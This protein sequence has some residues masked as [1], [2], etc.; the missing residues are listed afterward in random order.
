MACDWN[1][2]NFFLKEM[3]M[4]PAATRADNIYYANHTKKITAKNLDIVKKKFF[5]SMLWQT[6]QQINWQHGLKSM[7]A[8]LVYHQT[9]CPFNG[10]E[11]NIVGLDQW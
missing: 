4:V 9:I 11:Q 10:G 1:E 5:S 2:F 8:F 7:K 3:T 6:R